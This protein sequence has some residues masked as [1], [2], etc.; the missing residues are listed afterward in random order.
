MKVP[1]NDVGETDRLPVPGTEQE[2]RLAA[3]G[4]ILQNACDGWMKIDP[5]DSTRCLDAVL[6]LAL[7]NLLVDP[8]LGLN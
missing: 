5:S 2:P 6:N 8:D 7:S 3:L 1:A 4:E